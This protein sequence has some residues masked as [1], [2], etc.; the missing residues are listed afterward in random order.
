MNVWYASAT[1]PALQLLLM[2]SVY[3][4]TSGSMPYCEWLNVCRV[5]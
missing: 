4:R 1:R 5:V 2:I 3:V